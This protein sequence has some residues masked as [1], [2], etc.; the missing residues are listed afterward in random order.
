MDFHFG[1]NH[2]KKVTGGREE[3]LKRPE[4]DDVSHLGFF[5]CDGPS[6]P[7]RLH[8]TDGRA[9]GE[10][11]VKCC[12]QVDQPDPEFDHIQVH[13]PVCPPAL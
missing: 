11:E 4:I 6:F 10:H 1:S 5:H 2:C 3:R 7:S 8:P 13:F 9:D 12:R